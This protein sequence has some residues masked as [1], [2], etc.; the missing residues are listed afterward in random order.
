MSGQDY[1]TK[2]K[3]KIKGPNKALPEGSK[4]IRGDEKPNPQRDNNWNKKGTP[5]PPPKNDHKQSPPPIPTENLLRSLKVL[6]FYI[7]PRL[8]DS[9]ILLIFVTIVLIYLFIKKRK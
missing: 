1:L 2:D 5:P 4:S 9:I 6:Y 8:E 3:A 7:F